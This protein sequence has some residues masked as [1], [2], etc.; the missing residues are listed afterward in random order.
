[1]IMISFDE[2]HHIK[3]GLSLYNTRYSKVMSFHDG[4]AP[5]EMHGE[6]F[7]IDTNN[8]LLYNRKFKKAYGF[9]EG[10][11][12]V[13][14]NQ[15]WFHIHINGTA[16]YTHR[17]SWVGNFQESKCVVRDFD[18]NYFHI[19]NKGR[20]IYEEVYSYVGD[21]KY[22]IAVVLNNEGQSTHINELGKTI[23]N[24]YFEDLDVYHKGCAIAKDKNGYFH[25]DKNGEALYA[26]RYQKLEPFY[27]GSAL[28][29]NFN[30]QKVIINEKDISVTVLTK[31][32][33]NKEQILTESFGFF[34]YQVLFS[35]LKLE[36]LKGIKYN[37]DLELPSVS[38]KLI[39]RWLRVEDII[40]KKGQLTIKGK[41]I[42]NELKPLILYWQDLPFKVSTNLIE[43]LKSG[44]EVFTKMYGEPFFDYLKNDKSLQELTSSVHAY[45]SVDYTERIR[46]LL[47]SNKSVC[48]IGG[49]NGALLNTIKQ[50]YKD[51]KTILADKFEIQ[52]QHKFQKIDFFKPFT[53]NC[54][55]FLLSR[56][57]H[58]WCD[59]KAIQILTHISDNMISDTILYIF[60]TLIPETDTVDKGHTLSFHLLS[61]LGGYERT[62]S[63]YKT[64]LEI[65]GLKIEEVYSPD[66]L[67]SII[68]VKK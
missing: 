47:L 26:D 39:F 64:L 18:N 35:I 20:P 1:M 66:S 56:I 7:F 3:D 40:D 59:D 49:G 41:V 44:N 52:T 53:I 62:L 48:D 24:K 5:V 12:A 21:F 32:F 50:M 38:K 67:I 54:D 23:H 68:K 33:I 57:L 58:D 60:E 30:N 16:C 6:S 13:C 10:L 28:A 45:Y 11:A 55:V 46:R 4:I 43:S 22:S 51:T 15:G 8:R 61:F 31:E 65:A 36:V 29:T 63:E 14:D 17:Y 37:I 19:D 25:I 42:E 34:K 27:N 2:T 9:Y